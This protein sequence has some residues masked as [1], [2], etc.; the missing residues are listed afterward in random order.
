MPRSPFLAKDDPE[1]FKQD[2]ATHQALLISEAHLPPSSDAKLHQGHELLQAIARA[3]REANEDGRQSA[4]R[5]IREPVLWFADRM[6]K[7]LR[8]NDHKGHWSRCTNRYL[9]VRLRTELRELVAAASGFRRM[10]KKKL[11]TDADLLAAG[12]AVMREAADVANFAMMIA[13]NTR[14]RLK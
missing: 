12:E 13:D 10:T 14:A 6:E 2:W 3:L 7:K 11:S 5:S 4:I 8:E 9:F 1:R